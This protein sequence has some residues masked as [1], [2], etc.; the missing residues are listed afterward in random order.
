MATQ[1]RIDAPDR[2]PP[3]NLDAEKSVLGSILLANDVIDDVL[4]VLRAEHFYND[5]NRE[6]FATLVAMNERGLRGLDPVTV[7]E[8]L[9]RRGVLGEVGG[10]LYVHDILESVPHAAHVEYYARIVR[11]KWVERTLIGACHDILKDSYDPTR[12]TVDVL[13]SA[14]QRIFSIL[15]Q[16]ESAQNLA[17]KDILL[18]TWNRINERLQNAGTIS[19]IPSGFA[20]LDKGTNGFQR[21]EL[22]IL[23]A[24]PSMGKTAFVCNVAEA[25]AANG[26]PVVLFSLEQS[27]LEL[28]ERLLCIRS[29]ID[30]HKLR[31]GDLEPADRHALM[32]A[33]QELSEMPLFIDDQPGRKMS[34]IAAICRRIKRQHGCGMVVIDYLQLVEAEDSR[35]PREQQVAQITRR[36]KF[37]A[38]ELDAPV[39]ALSQLNRGVETRKEGDKRPRL[40]DLRES[41]AIEQDADVVML[42]HR[43]EVYLDHGAPDYEE[44]LDAVHGLA[45]LIVAKN[46]SGPTDV[47]RLTW[48]PEFMRFENYSDYRTPDDVSDF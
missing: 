28:A 48:R 43:P 15:E 40:A 34:A 17:I 6:I 13:D 11:E 4:D 41:G 20:D 46:R 47:V 44:R 39:I 3:Q 25:V 36:L 31:G 18:A 30:G 33:S 23:A 24:R 21:S 35:Q 45:E 5:A 26:F 2:L 29:R 32:E 22:I 8:E 7:A 9:E 27:K 10:P 1:T 42:L 19:G 16:Q 37:L 14:E 38:K 12:D